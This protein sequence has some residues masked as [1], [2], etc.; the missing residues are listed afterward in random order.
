MCLQ[1]FFITFG[2][3][4]IICLV[5]EGALSPSDNIAAYLNFVG[6]VMLAV[7]LYIDSSSKL[8]F[9]HLRIFP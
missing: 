7:L 5:I 6:I 8:K 3:A 1:L 9:F 2:V 4:G